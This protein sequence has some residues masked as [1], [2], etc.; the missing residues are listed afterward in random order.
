[1]TEDQRDRWSKMISETSSNED[2]NTARLEM[3]TQG[4]YVFGGHHTQ[5][6]LTRL[7]TC[8][9]EDDYIHVH[10][11]P[12]MWFEWPALIIG[13]PKGFN[14]YVHYLDVCS[15]FDNEPISLAPSWHDRVA[16]LRNR[17]VADFGTVE[18]FKKRKDEG[19]AT[20]WMK[21]IQLALG[22]KGSRGSV[23]QMVQMVAVPH[24]LWARYS[25]LISGD[26]V[27]PA[28]DK[29]GQKI[30]GKKISS[31][32]QIY[33][34]FSLKPERQAHI[35]DSVIKGELPFLKAIK[36]CKEIGSRIRCRQYIEKE[37]REIGA[38]DPA[39]K[40]APTCEWIEQNTSSKSLLEDP[41]R[42]A[43]ERKNHIQDP[44]TRATFRK[45]VVTQW[46]NYQSKKKRIIYAS[47]DIEHWVQKKVPNP[48]HMAS[49][50]GAESSVL[51]I[52]DK[53]ENL[54]KWIKP[55]EFRKSSFLF[56]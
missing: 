27:T 23:A 30:K 31:T 53:T 7:Q 15:E 50:V 17:W 3:V 4:L 24:F 28:V 8:E 43:F 13:L 45:L 49:I 42:S 39:T 20:A 32:S 40:K 48:Q 19:K 56:A 10:N 51:V 22:I 11:R 26:F 41:Y 14:N 54:S 52:K 25:K 9:L 1:M 2:R 35:L 16:K 36:L 33:Q 5:K 47:D 44:K 6:V 46:K 37:F 34:C 21:D 18:E 38:I 55:Q 12:K 29:K